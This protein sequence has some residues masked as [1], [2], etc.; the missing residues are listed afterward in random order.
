M[1]PLNAASPVA[2]WVETSYLADAR[3]REHASCLGDEDVG[4][5]KRRVRRA[6]E[7]WLVGQ[8]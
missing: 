8:T 5:V 1:T 4:L 7:E 3:I 2:A 6:L